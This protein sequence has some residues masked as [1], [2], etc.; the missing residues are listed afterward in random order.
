[1]PRQLGDSVVVITG[2][3]SG[4]GRA[5]AKEFAV[6]GA[7]VV[8]AARNEEALGTLVAEIQ[9]EGGRALAVRTD[10]AEPE[11]LRT[12]AARAV[13][14]YGGIDTWVNN[15]ALSIYGTVEEITE[16]EF[17]QVTR[18]NY[19]GQVYGTKAA[20]P[21]LRR[22][23]DGAVIGVGSVE[24]YRAVPLQAPYVASK[25]AVRG[26]Y[27]TLRSELI[28]EAAPIAV[29]LI[30]PASINTPLFEH[31]RSKTGA[32]PRVPPPVYQP[33]V[34][35]EAI[36]RAAERPTREVP[37][38]G[39]A[40]GFL[41]GQRLSPAVTDVALTLGGAAFKGQKKDEPDDGVDN[42][43]APV[44]GPGSVRGTQPGIKFNSSAFTRLVGHLPRP[45]DVLSDLI[46]E[47]RRRTGRG[48][49]Q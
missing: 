19:L 9:R 14:T 39:S 7:K 23:G 46:T 1:M 12:L 30:L 13:E 3:S 25:F 28:A 24:S 27:D 32:Q 26:F 38:G 5:T 40:V 11:Q 15:A 29:T 48:A 43:N 33:E 8:V 17:D 2:A 6:K 45:G 18:V 49:D 20:L 36:V 21:H 35:A 10:V 22:S 41:L 4:I 31:A 42:L 47:T 37:V 34:V 16:E 44:P